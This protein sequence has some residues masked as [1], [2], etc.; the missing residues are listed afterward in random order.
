MK[1]FDGAEF[2]KVEINRF[3]SYFKSSKAKGDKFGMS[4][5]EFKYLSLV[6]Q[7]RQKGLV[8]YDKLHQ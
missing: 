7:A 1:S 3:A 5:F 4:Y 8:D 2:L 6:K